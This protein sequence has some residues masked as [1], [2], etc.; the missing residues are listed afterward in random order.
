VGLR[1]VNFHDVIDS[2]SI[3]RRQYVI[4]AFCSLLMLF[5]GFDT[6]VIS[7]I[8]PVLAK[9]WHLPK[10]AF[11]PIFSAVFFGL[12][13]GNFGVPF[14]T[15]RIG[16]KKTIIIATGAF[17]LFTL[18]AAFASSVPQLITLRVLT[19]IG[20]GAATPC[21]VSLVSEFSPKRTR[22]TFVMLIY[23]GYSLGFVF[24][25][26]CCNALIPAFGWQAPMWLGSLCALAVMLLLI[27]SLSESP[28]Y[29]AQRQRH[30]D[31]LRAAKR[32]FPVYVLPEGAELT[33]QAK[34]ASDI[35]IKGLFS[36]RLRIGTF[37]MWA[38]F[39]INLGAFYF[40]QSWL[41]TVLASISFPPNLVVWATALMIIGGMVA[42]F[43][44]APMMDRISPYRMLTALYIV[45]GISMYA[46]SMAI[47]A[48]NW[49]LLATIFCCGFC[50]SGG[51]L[52]AVALGSLFYP[53]GLRAPG[54]AW[55]YGVGRLGA[56]GGT[57][58]A[59]VMYANNWTADAMFRASAA[60]V[61]IA[62]VCVAA[63]GMRY[64]AAKGSSVPLTQGDV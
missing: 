5:D 11:G 61:L 7:F 29:L 18:L 37:L 40:L 21:A 22:A 9:E 2:H 8:V 19:G 36:P 62:A 60:P 12:L 30:A 26:F 43:V 17:G 10:A 57:Y 52:C 59:G 13:I 32:L 4:L 48:S 47:S 42:G 20:L 53:G 35:S 23:I 51:Q 28:A 39:V 1:Q 64:S 25:G 3:G 54:V 63:M 49:V 44:V 58:L 24:A 31:L 15:Q 50:I 41:P 55:A 46:I 33:S 27:P 6:Q 56:A 38:I 14:L 45:G 16:T 34:K